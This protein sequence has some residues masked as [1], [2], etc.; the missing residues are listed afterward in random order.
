MNNCEVAQAAADQ[1]AAL[2]CLA[3]ASRPNDDGRLPNPT[4]GSAKPLVSATGSSG[5]RDCMADL[6]AT[7][8]RNWL[9]CHRN[10]QINQLSVPTQPPFEE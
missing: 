6:P 7:A 5:G 2:F 4:A 9:I 3:S 1:M 10:T 8:R